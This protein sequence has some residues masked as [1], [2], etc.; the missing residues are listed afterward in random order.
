MILDNQGRL[1]LND[2]S[3]TSPHNE[4]QRSSL[5]CSEAA[6]RVVLQKN[7]F[8]KIS[9]ISQE[10]TYVGVSFQQ[11][12]RQKFHLR[13]TASTCFTSKY[14]NKQ[15]WRVWTRRDLERVQS[16]YFSKTY[17]SSPPDVFCK[18]GVLRNSQNSQE[19]TCARVSLIIR[20]QLNNSGGCF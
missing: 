14:Y 7:V 5:V 12:C 4:P 16:K 2:H 1:M 11:H 8:L 15:Y 9:Q 18:K 6:T 3:I 19:N 20:L 13:K 17:R 10:N